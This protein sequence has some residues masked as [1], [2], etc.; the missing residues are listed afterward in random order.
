MSKEIRAAFGKRWWGNTVLC[1]GVS[2]AIIPTIRSHM[3]RTLTKSRMVARYVRNSP[4]DKFTATDVAVVNYIQDL[5]D[6]DAL[7]ERITSKPWYSKFIDRAPRAPRFRKTAAQK[8]YNRKGKRKIN[9]AGPAQLRTMVNRSAGPSGPR[10]MVNR[11][12]GAAGSAGSAEPEE[13][14]WTEPTSPAGSGD[15][16]GPSRRRRRAS[17]MGSL[18]NM[19]GH[20]R[21]DILPHGDCMFN[22]L[23]VAA[24]YV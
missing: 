23:G 9:N 11:S 5:H 17:M 14:V 18:V 1:N 21:F 15:Q 4:Q 8:D 12:A 22:S 7:K 3:K 16:S 13:P 19:S 2:G 20:Y 24:L 6:D 10:I